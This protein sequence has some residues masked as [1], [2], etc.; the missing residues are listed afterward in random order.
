MYAAPMN[1]AEW[2]AL[3]PL[4]RARILAT[5]EQEQASPRVGSPFPD[6]F[7][8][9]YQEGF[10]AGHD[11]ATKANED[12]E[13]EM[14]MTIEN[15]ECE[16]RDLNDENDRLLGDIDELRADLA[17]MEANRDYWEGIAMQSSA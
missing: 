2:D 15:L 3:A 13:R 16:V 8:D 5:L 12:T 9:A 6:V 17:R 11:E 4:L 14:A 1:A 10:D 7:A